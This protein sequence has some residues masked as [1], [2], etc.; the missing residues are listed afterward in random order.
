MSA[1]GDA[2]L[3]S[4]GR[5]APRLVERLRALAELAE[6]GEVNPQLVQLYGTAIALR[7]RQPEPRIPRWD[8]IKTLGSEVLVWAR[9]VAHAHLN[10]QVVERP[11]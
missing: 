11:A 7:T 8:E 2:V 1:L 5:Y 6:R 10:A 3:L 4:K 9:H